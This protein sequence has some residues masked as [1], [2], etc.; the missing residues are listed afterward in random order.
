MI[1]AIDGPAGAGKSTVAR[2]LARRLG[3]LY[4][5][6]GAMYRAITLEALERGLD[7]HDE[8]ECGRLAEGVRL[9]FSTDGSILIDGRRGEPR[10]R[11]DERV[12]RWV[13]I[14][15]AHAR[16]RTCIVQRQREI[17]GQHKS[18]GGLVA[19]GRDTAT[20]VF[21]AADFKFF[22]TAKLSTR[23]QRRA[24]ELSRPA[25]EVEAEIERRDRL[26]STRTISPLELARDS[27][28]VAT[29]GLSADQVTEQL[30]ARIQAESP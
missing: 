1:V 8:S 18:R 26:D 25:A 19:E 13:S 29:D 23:A 15:A 17:A 7:P 11:E 10:I 21:P 22:L 9:D 30:F 5:D 28:L 2:A 20:A 16:V 27:I 12:A 3:Y 4:L 24:Q 14:V 6:T